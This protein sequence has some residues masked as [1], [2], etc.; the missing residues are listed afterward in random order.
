LKILSYGYFYRFIFININDIFKYNGSLQKLKAGE[1]FDCPL[2]YTKYA[3]PFTLLELYCGNEK[4]YNLAGS[5][6][7]WQDKVLFHIFSF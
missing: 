1:A 2:F 6:Q 4:H 7:F 3:I 5:L